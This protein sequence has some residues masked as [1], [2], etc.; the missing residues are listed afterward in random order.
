MTR[1]TP[2][3][4]LVPAALALGLLVLAGCSGQE[5]SKSAAPA[6]AAASKP[7]SSE[8]LRLKLAAADRVD[9]TEDRVVTQCAGC[10]LNMAGKAEHAVQIE[11]YTLHLCSDSCKAEFSKDVAGNVAA[12]E[13]PQT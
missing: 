7:V 5:A 1:I 6:P 9:G 8:D 4:V 10:R 3:T 12:L 2:Q 11:G 13:I